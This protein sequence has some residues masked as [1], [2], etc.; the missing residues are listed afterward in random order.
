MHPNDNKVYIF[1][2]TEGL[3]CWQIFVKSLYYWEHFGRRFPR[4]IISPLNWSKYAH[5]RLQ[6]QNALYLRWVQEGLSLTFWT[7]LVIATRRLLS[8]RTCSRL[9]VLILV[10]SSSRTGYTSCCNSVACSASTMKV[11]N[12]IQSDPSCGTTSCRWVQ[13][14]MKG[15][16]LARVK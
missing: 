14:Q 4:Y 7:R 8:R 9:S 16:G 11:S 15:A 5:R 10:V 6:T 13:D 12:P 3:N 2:S 1:L